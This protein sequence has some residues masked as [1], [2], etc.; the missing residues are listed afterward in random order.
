VDVS[1][2]A[3]VVRGARLGESD[4]ELLRDALLAQP[5]NAI[6]S[7]AF[8]VVTGGIA[9]ATVRTPVDRLRSAIFAVCLASI[10]LGSFLYHGP[11]PSGSQELHDLPIL[12]TVTSI[13][14]WNL[15]LVTHSVRDDLVVLAAAAVVF[16]SITAIDGRLVPA[17]T[18]L[19]IGAAVA[20][21]LVVATRGLRPID[22]RRH[23]RAEASM[24]GVAA[25]ATATWLLGRT[26]SP[27]CTPDAIFQFHGLW[28]LASAV[29]LALW[30]RLAF[31]LPPAGS[32]NNVAR[33]P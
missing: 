24:F 33:S 13:A 8:V 22:G 26:G 9:I 7:L 32:A 2:G 1:A 12:L 11:Q 21:E 19:M 15:R 4:C 6:T 20:L 18:G 27:A 10:G 5:V 29:L 23:S 28:H 17:L 30:W 25:V 3:R 16:G 14:I 31:W